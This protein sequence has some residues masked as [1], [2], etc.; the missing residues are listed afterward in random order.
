MLYYLWSFLLVHHYFKIFNVKKIKAKA[1]SFLN[2][3]HF[4]SPLTAKY[5]KYHL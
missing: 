1:K 2:S 3:Y 4:N 5:S